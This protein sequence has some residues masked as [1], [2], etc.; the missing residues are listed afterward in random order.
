MQQNADKIGIKVEIEALERVAEGRSPPV[1]HFEMATQQTSTP[2]D[3]THSTGLAPDG[4]GAYGPPPAEAC[5]RLPQEGRTPTTFQR[6]ATYV[7]CQTQ[8]LTCRWAHVVPAY[9]YITSKGLRFS[10]DFFR[11]TGGVGDLAS[12]TS[13]PA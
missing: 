3:Q 2:L 12:P 6:Q 1:E 4:P 5:I 7:K 11:K 9:N 8:M 10:S 13:P